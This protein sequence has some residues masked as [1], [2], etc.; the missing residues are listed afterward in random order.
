[1]RR[2]V[3][4]QRRDGPRH[5]VRWTDHHGR[6]RYQTCRTKKEAESFQQEVERGKSLGIDLGKRVRFS[7]GSDAWRESHLAHGLRP[8]SRKD[9]EG[10]LKWLEGEFGNREIRT[11]GPVDLERLRNHVI[12]TVRHQQLLKFERALRRNPA[13]KDREAEIRAKIARSGNRAA[14]KVIGC[15]GTLWR[16]FVSRGYATRNVA[17]DVRKPK[18]ERSIESDVIDANILNPA[19]IA[20]LIAA[21]PAEHR[22]AVSFLFHTGVRFGE[23]LGLMWTDVDWNSGRVLIR[24]QRS[25]LNN[26]LTAPKTR[27]GTRWI[28]LPADLMTALKAHRLQTPGEFVFPLDARNWRTRVWHPALRR[29]G[30]R[31]VRI[32]DARH[33][34]ASLLIAAG[35]DIVAVSRRLGHA[36]PSITLG[37]YSHAVQSQNA[38]SLGEKLA[39]YMQREQTGCN[40]VVSGTRHEVPDT[41]VLEK[42]V[43]RAGI[44]PATRGFSVRCSTN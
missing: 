35:A 27:A 7:T 39:A 20:R 26:E 31:A 15:A 40:S 32:H 16:F 36:N 29:A 10:S 2:I 1:V 24:R 25:G 41:E 12:D 44:E 23:L 13:L 42:L 21:A 9:Y 11:I 33:T 4:V 17:L 14:A 38:P 22:M 28:D 37:V 3:K 43:A 5:V 19:E 8:A 18:V 34:H 6:N 30:L